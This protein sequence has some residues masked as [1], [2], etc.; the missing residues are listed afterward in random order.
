MNEIKEKR[1]VELLAPAGNM[2]K[3]LTAFHFGADAVYLAGKNFGLRAF[4]DNFTQEE[5]LQATDVAHSADKKIYVTVNIFARNA[6]F[7][8]LQ[9]YLVFLQD[10]GVDG[11]IVSDAGV[12]DVAKKVAPRLSIHI[13]TQANVLNKY[14][15]EFWHK[16]GARRVVLARECKFEDIAEINSFVPTC[17]T[18]VF[19]HGAMCVSY[20]GRCLMSDF[21]TGRGANRGECVQACRWE[22]QIEEKEHTDK[23]LLVKEDARGTYIFNSK[24]LNLIRRI[25][26]LIECGVA[27]FKIEGRMKSPY[28]VATVVNAYRRAID[29]YYA[30][31][32][33]YV[34]DEKLAAELFKTTHRQFTEGFTF[35][36]GK[37]TQNYETSRATGDS[38]FLAVVKDYYDGVA[39]IEMRSR[40]KEGQCV[41]ILSPADV[42]NKRVTIKNLRDINDIAVDDAKRVQ[43]ILK[44]DCP[45][46][47]ESGDIL[48]TV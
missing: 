46:K 16:Q 37:I 42:F 14:A 15:V 3:L 6:D 20:S 7:E 24:D 36:D 33:N 27:S 11:V 23:Q 29:A 34:T 4:A 1:K 43:Q 5:I 18:E 10:V 26:D 44:F 28:Y 30:N 47:L 45:C 9:E 48:R 32:E 17:E 40:F 13:S 35:D 2:E 39:T 8:E 12:V 25:K 19:I 38:E 22:W 41:E 21:L 31:P